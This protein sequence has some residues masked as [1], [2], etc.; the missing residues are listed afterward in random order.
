MSSKKGGGASGAGI[1]GLPTAGGGG[2]RH[3]ADASVLTTATGASGGGAGDRDRER[4]RAREVA[5]C[6]PCPVTHPASS[7][8]SSS[9]S[10]AAAMALTSAADGKRGMSRS[11]SLLSMSSVAS[12][13]GV[14]DIDIVSGNDSECSA[15]PCT[16]EDKLSMA[17]EKVSR[18]EKRNSS[19]ID[20]ITSY[21]RKMEEV[22]EHDCKHIRQLE[23]ELQEERK[24]NSELGERTVEQL[25]HLLGE[26]SA[27]EQSSSNSRLC[28]IISPLNS[29][30]TQSAS[31]QQLKFKFEMKGGKIKR[32]EIVDDNDSGTSLE[33]KLMAESDN[34]KQ[35]VVSLL[36]EKENIQRERQDLEVE[37]QQSRHT[38]DTRENTLQE[39]RSRLSELQVAISKQV[40]EESKD[41]DL[42]KVLS[43]INECLLQVSAP[44][45]SFCPSTAPPCLSSPNATQWNDLARKIIPEPPTAPSVDATASP[46]VY[47]EAIDKRRQHD[48]W[49]MRV[50]EL[51][52]KLMHNSHLL[53]LTPPKP[54]MEEGSSP[55]GMSREE[56]GAQL[57]LSLLE[58]IRTK[59]SKTPAELDQSEKPLMKLSI[60]GQILCTTLYHRR[61]MVGCKSGTVHMVRRDDGTS[62]DTEIAVPPVRAMTTIKSLLWLGCEDHQ[63][64]VFDIND[65]SW[66]R[67]LSGHQRG[68]ITSV[69]NVNDKHIWSSAADQRI[70]V[71]SPET[72]ECLR[73]INIQTLVS[74]MI[75]SGSFVWIGTIQGL[76]ICDTMYFKITGHPKEGVSVTS[77]T[78][79]KGRV[80]STDEIWSAMGDDTI[81]ICDAQTGTSKEL[82]NASRVCDLLSV[83]CRV[84]TCSWDK[85]I[86]IWDATT[87]YCLQEIPC[88]RTLR[89]LLVVP[90]KKNCTVWSGGEDQICI[91]DTHSSTHCLEVL[92]VSPQALCC[93][94]KKSISK[95][96][97][98]CKECLDV[99]LHVKCRDSFSSESNLCIPIAKLPTP[100]AIPQQPT[101]NNISPRQTASITVESATSLDSSVPSPRNSTSSSTSQ[102]Q[103]P[104]LS[105]S[106]PPVITAIS[107]RSTLSLPSS[108]STRLSARTKRKSTGSTA[109]PIALDEAFLGLF[110]E[111]PLQAIQTLAEKE[112]FTANPPTIAR[113]LHD[114]KHQLD[115]VAVGELI[116]GSEQSELLQEYIKLVDFGGLDFEMSLRH[117]LRCFSLPGEGQRIDRVIQ[118]YADYTYA[119]I[120][121]LKDICGSSGA[122]YTLSYSIIML[123]TSLHNP[124][125]LAKM[126]VPRWVDSNTGMNTN[127]TDF[128]RDFLEYLYA[129]IQDAPL[130]F[131][132][133]NETPLVQ[134]MLQ[135][136]G[137][138]TSRWVW[139]T[140]FPLQI[141]I[142]SS[143]KSHTP[144]HLIP[145]SNTFF[146]RISSTTFSLHTTS[147]QRTTTLTARSPYAGAIWHRALTTVC[148]GELSPSSGDRK[149]L[150]ASTSTT[151]GSSA[152]ATTKSTPPAN[153]NTLQLPPTTQAPLS[154]RQSILSPRGSRLAPLFPI[155][156]TTGTTSST[157]TQAAAATSTTQQSS[158]I[159]VPPPATSNKSGSMPSPTPNTTPVNRP[160]NVPPLQLHP[161]Q[162]SSTP[163]TKSDSDQQSHKRHSSNN[164][165]NQPQPDLLPQDEE[166]QSSSSS[167]ISIIPPPQI[168]ESPPIP[169][170]LLPPPSHI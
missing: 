47:K 110:K 139:C 162:R 60:P 51:G 37:L 38:C 39:L 10:S 137:K 5:S 50:H 31:D 68:P 36:K 83:G 79:V 55:G 154:P 103:T 116:S 99:T 9:S 18:L 168:L 69:L 91:W 16:L 59:D 94:C 115:P 6:D 2:R 132:N 65:S 152:P 108:S 24:K 40:A 107:P 120:G 14:S 27:M 134:G 43:G 72:L 123:N 25:Q 81:S 166:S 160:P 146:K 76:Y 126:T 35:S 135:K 85:K 121:E 62:V 11:A 153:A 147:L 167:S 34:L 122:L 161:P 49:E 109:K 45:K 28:D 30:T 140:L 106:T 63:L 131:F 73:I 29:D 53:G 92:P 61:V 165:K 170:P 111:K 145:T 78:V 113:F 46:E 164:N 26:L 157:T 13:E 88:S 155:S 86:G 96:A 17:K 89:C 114:Y 4:E 90:S 7:S 159:T 52:R 95:E 158:E 84:W 64:R 156:Q 169:P 143:S 1:S 102:F 42:N 19:C 150:T 97:L 23:K 119:V 56:R 144:R 93:V 20:Y 133:P 82:I 141:Y 151:L 66:N 54:P 22:Q 87:R 32:V 105:S 138:V 130:E 163:A 15:E 48:E 8:S 67:T 148:K 80:P 104:P 21:Q 33:Q 128:Q 136:K 3:S 77:M 100:R 71:W 74:K 58:S 12:S 57:V 70:C 124:N 125:A 127:E 101:S 118:A 41:F 98:Q 112:K 117:W 44:P 142:F 149:G 75:V 129:Q